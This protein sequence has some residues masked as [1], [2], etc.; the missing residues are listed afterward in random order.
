MLKTHIYDLLLLVFCVCVF[1][2]VCT[3]VLPGAARVGLV[4][5]TAATVLGLLKLN[6]AGPGLSVSLKQ[7]WKTEEKSF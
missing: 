1:V 2:C 4:V 6:V 3:C 5:M 7:M